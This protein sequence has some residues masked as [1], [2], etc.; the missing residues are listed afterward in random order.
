MGYN[1]E[2]PAWLA[3]DKRD[4]AQRGAM[5]GQNILQG[6]KFQAD[7]RAYEEEEPLRQA[8]LGMFVAQKKL[9]ETDQEMAALNAGLM[10]NARLGQKDA[11]MLEADIA[12]RSG[13]WS[14]PETPRRMAELIDQYPGLNNTE[15]HKRMLQNID[16]SRKYRME[17]DAQR[18]AD[19]DRAVR[20]ITLKQMEVDARRAEKLSQEGPTR[21]E[22]MAQGLSPEEADLEFQ[23][24]QK[25]GFKLNQARSFIKLK[26]DALRNE[27]IPV[28]DN[29]I[30]DALGSYGM[31][32]VALNADAQEKKLINSADQTSAELQE[33]ADEVARFDALFGKGSF[34][35]YVGPIDNATF[36]FKTKRA[37]SKD[38]LS[39]A[40][41]QARSIQQR[42]AGIV[43]A[44]RN[45]NFGSALT[46]NEDRI[47]RNIVSSPADQD[48]VQ[49][50]KVFSDVLAGRAKRQVELKKF[51]GNIPLELKRKYLANKQTTP[52]TG[53]G[54][55]TRERAAQFLRDAGGDKERARQMARDAGFSF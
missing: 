24:N 30:T 39:D 37:L 51:A 22:L 11:L 48:Y 43:Q 20:D 23:S 15:W 29:E 38:Q 8:K 28:T 21:E 35:E 54:A 3:Q 49:S 47:F 42:V 5:L 26:A 17:L 2:F 14:D 12:S 40:D 18:Q 41:N 9:A 19:E 53:G 13:G 52:A 33:I 6:L 27:G 36:R 1:T 10:A 34:Q 45:Q 46:S 32:A 50:L 4:N 31:S 7:Q 16:T 25:G 44:Y 55:L